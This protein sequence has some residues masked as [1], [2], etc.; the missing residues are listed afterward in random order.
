[1]LEVKD[2]KV[3]VSLTGG[4]GN[5]LFQVAAALNQTQGGQVICEIVDGKPRLN[6]EAQPQIQCFRLPSNVEFNYKQ[7]QSWFYSKLFG[8]TLRSGY[9]PKGIEKTSLFK[10]FV[11]YA[12]SFMSYLRNRDFREFLID[13]DVGYSPIRRKHSKSHLVGYFQT[14]RWLEDQQ[15]RR[16]L[17]GI[18]L[19]HLAA[20]MEYSALAEVECPTMIH[21]RLTDYLQESS[22]GLLSRSYYERAISNLQKSG[23]LKPGS[24][25]WVFSDDIPAAKELLSF[26]EGEQIRWIGN[27][28]TCPGKTLELMRLCRNYIISNSTFSWWGASL[29]HNERAKVFFPDPWF[30]SA[31]IPN[32]L[33]PKSWIPIKSDWR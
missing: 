5:Q 15:T 24:K 33:T 20:G 6:S 21:V 32:D 19:P 26:I 18:S 30:R 2:K 12:N 4:L 29:S 22:F 7:K 10:R 27:E 1:M 25:F 8:Y 13:T 9:A 17:H 16:A 3:F 11:K 28:E 14:F 23:E 31:P